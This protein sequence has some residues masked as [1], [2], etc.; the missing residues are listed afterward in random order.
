MSKVV[1]IVDDEQPVLDLV[2][3]ILGG[4]GYT[5][6]AYL[7]GESMIKSLAKV[8]PSLILL[9]IK[10]P[11]MDGYK[12]CKILKSRVPDLKVCFVSAKTTPEDVRKGLESGAD[13]YI[14]KPFTES[15]LIAKVRELIGK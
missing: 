14:T 9:D 5:V 10:L 13:E 15:Q 2:K 3:E 8:T 4:A 6:E 7:D 1:Y 11:G 12:V